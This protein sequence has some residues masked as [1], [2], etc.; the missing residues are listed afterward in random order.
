MDIGPYEYDHI[1]SDI[2]DNMCQG[3]KSPYPFLQ[4]MTS[5]DARSENGVTCVK[6]EKWILQE[7][8]D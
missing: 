3:V 7:N 8:R 5:N 2:F 1:L 4:G 6:I